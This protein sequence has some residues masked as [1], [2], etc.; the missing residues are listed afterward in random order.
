MMK[1]NN[2]NSFSNWAAGLAGGGTEWMFF[3]VYLSTRFP[4][5]DGGEREEV[6]VSLSLCV[7]PAFLIFTG[8]LIL[9]GM[10]TLFAF[11]NLHS[12]S[13][14]IIPT[15]FFSL[16]PLS[17]SCFFL[18]FFLSQSLRNSYISWN[19][20]SPSPRL[21]IYFESLALHHH[22]CF[23]CLPLVSTRGGEE[24]GGRKRRK[25]PFATT[26]RGK[27]RMISTQYSRTHI[28]QSLEFGFFLT[29]KCGEKAPISQFA[30]F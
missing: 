26:E 19:R 5:N 12:F 25:D 20:N 1:T 8:I 29:K 17:G 23:R 4:R 7:C 11:A 22:F 30:F 28:Y 15:I 6:D 27:E 10:K 2:T 13:S 24:R 16:S 21:A 3:L 18:L 9:F 14:R